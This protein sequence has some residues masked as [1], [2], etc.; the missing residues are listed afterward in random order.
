MRTTLTL[1]ADVAALVERDMQQRGVTFKAAVN[2]AIRRGLGGASRQVDIV[3]PTAD[4]GTTSHDLDH[5]TALAAALE[6][7][8]LTRRLSVGR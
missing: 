2:D 4:L 8:E 3:F 1:E 5:A 6:D 7:E